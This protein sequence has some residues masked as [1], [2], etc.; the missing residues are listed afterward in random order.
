[1]FWIHCIFSD[2]CLPL[3]FRRLLILARLP[4]T[5]S[6]KSSVSNYSSQVVNP[7]S[8]L[9]CC[10]S[11]T[12][13][14]WTTLLFDDAFWC[15][16]FNLPVDWCFGILCGILILYQLLHCRLWRNEDRV[17]NDSFDWNNEDYQWRNSQA[18]ER[19]HC[20]ISWNEARVYRKRSANQ[21]SGSI[22][23]LKHW[24]EVICNA[25]CR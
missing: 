12:R 9:L 2:E 6:P 10:W 25:D 14:L 19:L 3:P 4:E 16:Y 13:V 23:L 18:Y 21:F 8:L 24:G 22:W 11:A 15:K 20:W 5:C 7:Q 1:M 17:E